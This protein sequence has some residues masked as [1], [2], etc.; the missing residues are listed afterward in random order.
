MSYLLFIFFF[1]PDFAVV[2][3]CFISDLILELPLG[4]AHRLIIEHINKAFNF[5]LIVAISILVPRAIQ[6]HR[7]RIHRNVTTN[8]PSKVI[9]NKN[10]DV[11]DLSV[12]TVVM[13]GLC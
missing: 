5:C 2:L 13:V 6:F 3:I 12:E 9:K 7:I 8:F 11:E 10:G 4:M 1:Y